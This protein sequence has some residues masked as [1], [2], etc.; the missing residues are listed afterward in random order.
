[1]DSLPGLRARAEAARQRLGPA[2]AARRMWRATSSARRACSTCPLDQKPQAPRMKGSRA[3]LQTG[4]LT[5]VGGLMR[6]TSARTRLAALRRAAIG[7]GVAR[8]PPW[9]RPSAPSGGTGGIPTVLGAIGH[10][11]FGHGDVYRELAHMGPEAARFL[12]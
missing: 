3:R 2:A 1:M 12:D 8:R 11:V 6:R 4:S 7:R 10:Q 9:L 5:K